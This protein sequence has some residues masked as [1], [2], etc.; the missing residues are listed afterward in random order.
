M[1]PTEIDDSVEQY[2]RTALWS[3]SDGDDDRSL[4]EG[5]SGSTDRNCRFMTIDDVSDETLAQAIEDCARF[6][7]ENQADCDACDDDTLWPHRF[8][9]SRNGHGVSFSD[10]GWDDDAAERLDNAAQAFGE[11][12]LY[13]GDDGK[14]YS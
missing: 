2:I 6:Y 8:W 13:I 4:G 10:D 1:R 5:D 12:N 3:S 7:S 14:I 11:V 9:L